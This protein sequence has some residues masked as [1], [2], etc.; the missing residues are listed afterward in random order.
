MCKNI[1]GLILF[2]TLFFAIG[3]GDDDPSVEDQMA[4]YIESSGLVF[5]TSPTGLR[6]NIPDAGEGEFPIS[7]SVVSII[8]KTSLTDGEVLSTT[9][10]E[11][12]NSYVTGGLDGF[13]EAVRMLKPGGSGTF[14]VPPSLGLG[15]QGTDQIPANSVL[16]YELTLTGIDNSNQTLI[17]DYIALNSLDAVETEDGIFH[18]IEQT[19]GAEKPTVDNTVTVNYNGYLLNGES[20]DANDNATFS[21]DGLIRGWQLAIPL[22][23]RGGS[24]T[25][26]IPPQLGYGSSGSGPI[27]GNAVLVFDIELVDF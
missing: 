15:D 14:L 20:F 8:A 22:L 12:L 16:V 21:L 10:G 6:Y 26:I 18:V 13:S 24:G 25:F 27:P 2:V 7:N 3:C 9:N 4:Q 1:L 23:G 11:S 19:G 5:E 17:N